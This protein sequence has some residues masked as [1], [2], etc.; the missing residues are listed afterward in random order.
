MDQNNLKTCSNFIEMES[1]SSI[2]NEIPLLDTVFPVAFIS[3][4]R[5]PSTPWEDKK[6]LRLNR[7]LDQ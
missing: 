1:Q 5:K 6:K 2:S 4:F 7:L 3:Q